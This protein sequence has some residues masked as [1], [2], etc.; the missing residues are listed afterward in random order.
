MFLT[1]REQHVLQLVVKGRKNLQIAR[2]LGI[3]VSTVKA[4]KMRVQWKYRQFGIRNLHELKDVL[5]K[6]EKNERERLKMGERPD[7]SLASA[8]TR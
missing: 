8:Q 6:L 3:K 7:R 1:E 5:L 4:Y 2:R